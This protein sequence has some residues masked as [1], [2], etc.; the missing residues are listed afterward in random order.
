VDPVVLSLP[1][2]AP[3]DRVAP[4]RRRVAAVDL[5]RGLV[6]VLM[7]IDH[8]RDYVHSAAMAFPPEDLAQT[9]PAIFLTRWITHFCAPVFMFTAGLGAY[10]RLERGATKAELSRFLW[11]RGLWL[12]VL[13]LTVV[14]AAFFFQLGYEPMLLLV[15]W[16]LGLSMVALAVLIH[17]PW[18]VLLA[19]SA[20]MILLH[21]LLDG[22]DP[23]AFGPLAGVWRVLHVQGLL[24]T[25]PL[26]IVAYPLVPWIGVMALG[27]C[28]G[29][30]YRLPAELRRAVLL[31]LGLA[32]V[33]G[34]IV[35]RALNGYGDP[36]PWTVQ[37]DPVMTA[38]SFLNATKYPPS[39]AFLLMTLGPAFAFLAWADRLQP[40]DGNPLLV[41]G[42]TPLLYFILHIPLV[43]AIAIVL[44]GL[45]YGT[46]PFLF[47]PPPT[48]GTPRELFPPD[49]GWD[50]W[51]TYAV[52]FVAVAML[53][54]VCRWF[55]EL[56]RRRKER[57]LSYL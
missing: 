29:R 52:C 40:R 44:T 23:A 47:L 51:V 21:N 26:I 9:T 39:L 34:F 4:A 7:A 1:V 43:H 32:M 5:L 19:V 42:R 18:R 30:L 11:T 45:R 57:W 48:L 36:R 13:E 6:M 41:F 24:S 35:L 14:R 3:P 12:V 25:E 56:R 17:L 53:Y 37:P 33:A 55:G 38:V 54:P 31:R 28:C 49:Y 50:L 46:A 20:G 8:T 16:A 22:I 27:F 15:L 10:F 2:K